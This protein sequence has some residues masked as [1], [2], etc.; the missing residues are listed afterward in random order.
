MY[1]AVLALAL[2]PAALH[3]WWT[4]AVFEPSASAVLP[5][6]HLAIAQRVSFVTMLC[7]V[8][9]ILTARWQAAWI[10]PAQ[11]VALTAT[12]YRA[13]RAM[14]GETWP[15]HR[16][17]SW[18]L[19]LHVGMF[20]LWWFVA[21]APALVAQADPPQ[22]WWLSGLAVTIALAWHH[23]SGGVLLVLLR[24]T[25]LER[26]DLDGH[27]QRVFASARVPVP[28]LWR[29][30]E[31]G[32]RLANAFALLSQGQRGVLF[33]DSL[34]DQLPADEL[35]AILA[36]EVAHLEQF[37]RRRLLVMYSVTTV[38]I[39][40]LMIGSTVADAWLPEFE[41]WIWIA[42][43][44]GVCGAMF[45]RAR[46]MHAHETDAD[47]RAIELCG[48]CE[49]LIRGLIRIYEIN[50]IPRRWSASAEAHATHP[51]LAR[52]IRL[53][54]ERAAAP[55]LQPA[56]IERMIIASS[57]PGRYA[58]ID[59][60]RVGFLWIDGLSRR[61]DAVAK[62]DDPATILDRADRI[63]RVA[64]DQLC[65][66][67]VST[68]RGTI[69]LT[70]VDRAGTRWS[71]PVHAADA[72]RVQAALDQ[73]DHLVTA[74]APR[75]D[76]GIRQRAAV[77]LVVL[78]AA[79]YNAI[80]AVLVPALLAL[81]RPTRPLMLA[82]AGALAGTAIASVNELD[83]TVVRIV[84]LGILTIAV[85]WSVR[86]P[87]DQQATADA[88]VWTWIERVG[89]LVPVLVGLVVAAA[90]AQDLF[91]LHAAIRDRGWLTAALAAMAVFC[92]VQ[93]SQ[94]TARRAG[95]AIAVLA[96]ATLV[97][98]SPWFMLHAVA[99]PLV[100]DMPLFE[101]KLVPVTA[102]ATRSITGGYSSVRVTPDGAHFVL[103]RDD[104][105]TAEYED[106]PDGVPQPLSFV[107]GAFDGWHREVRAFDVAV[108]DDHQLLI[109]DR[110]RGSS[111]L[112]AEEIRSGRLLWTITLPDVEVTTVQASPDG[113][114]RAFVQRGGQ[115]ER[116]DGR[117]G[118]SLFSTTRWTV[119]T[120]RQQYVPMLLNDG[121]PGALA[122]TSMWHEPALPSLLLVDWRE[123]RRLLY[124]DGSR[125]TE[126]AT[127]HLSVDCTTPPID[128]TDS[129]CVSFDGRTSRLWRVD[130]SNGALAPLGEMRQMAWRVSQ[131]SQHRLAGIINGRAVVT[132][133]DARTLVALAP[134][135]R[136]WALDVEVSRDIVVT[137]C[138]DADATTVSQYRLPGE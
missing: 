64:Y 88:P 135:K 111:H 27:F 54:R 105:E 131:P 6:R 90:N 18:R 112:R 82:L 119:A 58:V 103:A 55:D 72:A 130:L 74:P 23:W 12:T 21:V 71:M 123:T 86:R 45:L 127:S 115:F 134:D 56:P 61:S 79:P 7:T 40:M 8:A 92:F 41:S 11:F 19:R 42:S 93:A 122:V 126:I 9:I 100:A 129:V 101:E 3:W 97:V 49:A 36:H 110:K 65:E 69:A 104:E 77:L 102:L 128:V 43:V 96:T 95:L 94:R 68:S 91:G 28:D 80:G 44:I 52:R 84:L 53:I 2:L 50:H 137:V 46:R 108:I 37:N 63:E 106:N 13:R 136:C 66:L 109:L 17:L 22:A 39:L 48:D 132:D 29:A 59:H 35:T 114:W 25:R 124:V 10:L 20:G 60:D 118:V 83:V 113:R 30:G 78:L 125:T 81:R 121:G 99:D 120:D 34:L 1:W 24:A 89:L 138:L 38:L 75:P 117:V 33:F 4:R 107:V 85:L 31:A 133:L 51:S 32:G 5:E 16:Y 73:V 26:A 47:L 76:F 62:E 87:Q 15:F 98:G 70:A 14:F 67:R 57:E 116:V